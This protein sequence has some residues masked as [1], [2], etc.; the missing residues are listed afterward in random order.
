MASLFNMAKHTMT[1]TIRSRTGTTGNRPGFPLNRKRLP[2]LWRGRLG[3]AASL[4]LA[5]SATAC[6]YHMPIRQGNILSR[7]RVSQLKVGMTKSQVQFLLGT[8]MANDPFVPNKWTYLYYYKSPG[9]EVSE[10]ILHLYFRDQK[11]ARIKGPKQLKGEYRSLGHM[12][13]Q[14]EKNG[15]APSNEPQGPSTPSS[16]PTNPNRGGGTGP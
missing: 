2:G 5:I 3:L 6:V 1:H 14:P 10:R 13:E 15:P 12:A 9:N 16:R 11:L 8:P 4:M 7:D